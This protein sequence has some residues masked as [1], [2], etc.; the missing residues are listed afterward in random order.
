MGRYSGTLHKL[1]ET[2]PAKKGNWNLLLN[3][4]EGYA[5]R[6]MKAKNPKFDSPLQEYS[7]PSEDLRKELIDAQGPKRDDTP[8]RIS[9]ARAPAD[10]IA[11]LCHM[12]PEATRMS[13]D[14]GRLP[15]HLA[16]RRSSED[17][18]TDAVLRV[19]IIAYPEA[20]VHRDDCG[21]TPLHYL[22]WYHAHTRTS[23]LVD[24][25]CQPLPEGFFVG[26]KQPP[27]WSDETEPLP[28]IPTPDAANKIP[29]SASIVHDMKHGALPIHYAAAEGAS[30]EVIKSFLAV[31]P[32][33]KS[34]ADRKGRTPLAWFLGAG[35]L[36]GHHV[37]GEVIDPKAPPV[38]EKKLSN[39]VVQ[40]LVSSKVARTTDHTGRYPIHWAMHLIARD[41][42]NSQKQESST[43]SLESVQALMDNYIQALTTPDLRGLTPLHVLFD[44]VAQVQQSEWARMCRNKTFRD[45]VD[46][47]LGG[48]RLRRGY[49]PSSKLIQML[50]KPPDS[51][52]AMLAVGERP[53]CAAHVED[54]QGRLPLHLA[55]HVASSASAIRLLIQFHPTSLLHTTEETIQTPLHVALSSPYT[56]PLQ[57]LETM[58]LL[59][60]AYV[61][62][63]HGTFVDG[64][65][66]LKMED[67]SGQYPLH[68][69]CENQASLEVTRL[70]FMSYPKSVMFQ[71][72]SGDYPF[73]CLLDPNLF[74]ST[75]Q[76]GLTGGATL[77]MPMG[78]TSDAQDS[79]R[80]EQLRVLQQKMSL[81]IEPLCQDEEIMKAASS[82]HGILPLHICVAFDVVP[83]SVV[84]QMLN[85]YP[86]AV[87]TFTT[88]SG[89]AYSPMDLHE[90]RRSA[91]NDDEKW[92]MIR[93]LL[94]S[95]G[96]TL[97]VHRRQDDLLD[98]CARLIRDELGGRG[99]SHMTAVVEAQKIELATLDITETLSSIEPPEIDHGGRPQTKPQSPK[100]PKTLKAKQR[101][102][103]KSMMSNTK[104]EKSAPVKK[105]IYDDDA[106]LGYLVSPDESFGDDEYF[107]D[108]Q[109]KEEEYHSDEY[110]SRY[111]DDDM[112]DDEQANPS[113]SDAIENME[114]KEERSRK[115]KLEQEEATLSLTSQ[116]GSP[117][118]PRDVATPFLSDVAF[119]LWLFFAMFTD[120]ESPED[121][122]A[123]QVEFILDHLKF[124]TVQKLLMLPLPSYVSEYLVEECDSL[125][126]LGVQDVANA[127]CK[128]IMHMS[129]YFVG[130]FEFHASQSD[131]ILIHRSMDGDTVM[132]RATEHLASTVETTEEVDPGYAEASIWATGAAPTAPRTKRTFSVSNRSVC[133]KFMRS[134]HAYE[135]EVGCRKI[136]GVPVEDEAP[137]TS[138]IVPLINHF[139][140]LQSHRPVDEKFRQDIQD[141]R[142]Q[143]LKLQ[144]DGPAEDEENS[145]FLPDYPYAI[146]MPC[147]DD[148][149]LNDHLFHHGTL[150][151]DK[152][153]E[154]GSQVGKSLQL[155]HE[156]GKFDQEYAWSFHKTSYNCTNVVVKFFRTCSRQYFFAQR[157]WGPFPRRDYFEYRKILGLG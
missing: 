150:G 118:S 46:L 126:G 6:D 123:K 80:A 98:R 50:C 88:A 55:L 117:Q 47:V 111:D 29:R 82:A 133:F 121:H 153:R 14:K 122:Y 39:S 110:D 113:K 138:N 127:Y 13:D 60:Q 37:S 23:K 103:I 109:S 106:D 43:L 107:S 85:T 18:Q 45:D 93:E 59:M 105:S 79:F 62:S 58:K 57:T 157:C 128:A 26:I 44:T 66:V 108:E 87:K 33:S 76:R 77:A 65:L 102:I 25:F 91:N 120:P 136:M 147:S 67:A 95:F 41:F 78:W 70:L 100:K 68:Y 139:N 129:F 4:L 140:A 10:I 9:V 38:W 83:Y 42:Y 73:H 125:K 27:T 143:R 155:M 16:C 34:L 134:A 5:V 15:L 32:I 96:P 81:L 97:D 1:A 131:S 89:H 21:R 63:R 74:G 115:S 69:A 22:M 116:S 11:A 114:A 12:G 104:K 35:A 64:R 137:G 90:M 31:Y 119:R 101:P 142:F 72:A 149:N 49:E 61:T 52:V 2:G 54:L 94:F 148:G 28:E 19:L 130:R 7:A 124:S 146:V 112:F 92:H 71:N 86:S 30:V 154:I 145:I 53:T 36:V 48:S 132:V 156:T 20:L 152:I 40:L 84:C 51:N 151:M 8:L 141:E 144:S 24:F 3:Y 56:T 75:D 17:P 99:S 135:S